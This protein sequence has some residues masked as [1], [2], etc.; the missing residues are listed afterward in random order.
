[1]SS[2]AVLITGCSSGIGRATA[3]RLVRGDRLVYATARRVED[4]RELVDAGCRALELDVTDEASMR[5]AVAEVE[6]DHGAVGVLI[7]NAG[8]SQSGTIEETPL[9][10]VRKQFE[11]NV[12]GLVRLTQLVLPKMREQGRGKIVNLSSMGGKL[13]FPGGGFYHAT[14]HAIESI[15]D[16]LRFEVRGFGIDVILIEPGIIR[17]QFDKTA[18]GG[19]PGQSPDSPYVGFMRRVAEATRDAY[20]KGVLAKLGGEPDDVARVIEKALEARS[21]KARYTVTASAKALLLQRAIFSDSMWDAF[22]AQ[23]YLAS[24][25]RLSGATLRYYAVMRAALPLL[26]LLSASAA[27][28]HN[29]KI[30]EAAVVFRG[31]GTYQIDLGLDADAFALGMPPDTDSKLVAERMRELSPEE[32]EAA[33]DQ[34]KRSIVRLLR[35]RFD[36][37][38]QF[39]PVGFPLYGT[40][41]AT[42]AEIPTVLGTIARLVG[43][44]P[45][46]AKTFTFGA[47]RAFKVVQLTIFD[48]SAPEPARYTLDI[49][50][51]SPPFK[52]GGG[53]QTMT[54]SEVLRRY[55]ILG[56]EHIL[57]K[58][59]DHILFVLG[60]FLLSA[61]LR[62]LLL[63]ITA[64][65]VAHSVTLAL[66]MFGVVSLPSRLVESLIAASIAYVAVENICTSKLHAWRPAVVFG[67][68]LLHGLGFAS[69]LKELGLPRTQF[70]PALVSFN[71]GVELGQLS[72]VAL[73][74]AAVGWLRNKPYYRK[75]VVIPASAVIAAVGVYWAIQRAFF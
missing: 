10:L 32:F 13:T 24:R 51:D 70:V 18:V 9:E 3:L 21:P 72:V 66:S 1:M 75:A 45:D 22:L 16:A 48:P 15:S 62:P 60:L 33:V 5:A 73:A 65:T 56:Y 31:D 34:A 42:N 26:L 40:P 30:T 20:T 23:H 52:L 49:G 8:Y 14:K 59:V 36:G 46:G 71:V 44:V 29:F 67:F 37:E 28:A 58:G 53:E 55:T 7:N 74:F 39:P 63:Q 17:T 35:I 12:F 27:F 6:R 47:S 57:P 2:R 38:K 64:F 19:L 11:T 25:Q 68:G 50:E 41:A 61:Y 54:T 4:L 69:V 43:K